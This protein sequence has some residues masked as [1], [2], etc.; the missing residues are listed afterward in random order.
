MVKSAMTGA[1]YAAAIGR[2]GLS[3]ARAGVFF[4]AHPATS[5]RWTKTGPPQSVA[6]LLRAAE[7]LEWTLDCLALVTG[8]RR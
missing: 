8:S 6:M 5:K 2:L 7:R 4:G 1:E 3:Q